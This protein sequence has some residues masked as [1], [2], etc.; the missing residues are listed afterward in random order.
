M[1]VVI[2]C[3]MSGINV[4]AKVIH[5][6]TTVSCMVFLKLLFTTSE[7]TPC[8]IFVFKLFYH[9]IDAPICSNIT[10]YFI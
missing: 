2:S 1:V 3:F 6:K 9:K 7:I 10:D 4:F 8:L 5:I